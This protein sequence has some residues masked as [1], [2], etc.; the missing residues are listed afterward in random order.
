M[1]ITEYK[2]EKL[3]EHDEWVITVSL[4]PT[5]FDRTFMGKIFPEKKEFHGSVSTWRLKDGSPVPYFWRWWAFAAITR[6]LHSGKDI[7]NVSCCTYRQ[8]NK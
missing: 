7:S 1:I 2:I 4:E 5:W 6:H 8:K 3:P